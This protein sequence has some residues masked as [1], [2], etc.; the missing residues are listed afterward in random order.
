M[1]L[2]GVIAFIGVAVCLIAICKNRTCRRSLRHSPNEDLEEIEIPTLRLGMNAQGGPR[3]ATRSYRV[4]R[5]RKIKVNGID[6]TG[7]GNIHSI[8]IPDQRYVFEL[9]LES[10]H[11]ADTRR[12]SYHP[13]S[14]CN[15]RFPPGLT[16][17][18]PPNR[19]DSRNYLYHITHMA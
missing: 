5:D 19:N 18:G 4:E 7:L 1:I 2:I 12:F 9:L 10:V 13:D 8:A 14:Q 3:K 6:T 17:P 16:I 11:S 15:P